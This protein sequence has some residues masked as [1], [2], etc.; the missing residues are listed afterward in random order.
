MAMVAMRVNHSLLK[1][2]G[3]AGLEVGGAVTLPLC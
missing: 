2:L 1:N 3:M